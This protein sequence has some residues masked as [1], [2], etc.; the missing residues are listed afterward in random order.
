MTLEL[1]MTIEDAQ[2]FYRE[3]EK[4]SNTPRRWKEAQ[5]WLGRNDLFYLLSVLLRRPDVVHPWVFDRCRMVQMEPNGFL[6]LWSREHF[7]SSIITFGLTIQDVLNDP[8][9]TIAIFSHTKRIARG[10]LQQIMRELAGND[11]LKELYQDV[12][13]LNP[14]K[15]APMWSEEL[16]M[17][18]RRSHNPKEATIEAHGLVDGQPTSK[19]FKLRVYD[20]VV[21][22]ESV[23]TGDQIEKTTDAWSLSE[24]LGVQA[25]KGGRVRYIGTRYNLGDTYSEIIKRGAAI[26]RIFPATAN[27]RFDGEPVFFSQEE[28]DIR[29]RNQSRSTVAAQLLQNPMADESATFV[30]SWL[31]AYDVRPRTINVYIMVDPSMGRTATADCTA[32]AVVGVSATGGKYLLD[33]FCHRMQLSERWNRLKNLYRKWSRTPGVQHVAV[34]YERY[35]MQSDLEYINERMMLEHTHFPITELNWTR[36]NTNSKTERVAR[37]EPDFRNGRFYLSSAV[38]SRGVASYWVVGTN[39]E[40]KG[41]NEVEIRPTQG[42]SRVQMETIKS[43]SSDLVAKALKCADAE[44]K[45]YDLT[46]TFIEEYSSFP[47]GRL[48]DL[49]DAVSRIYDM[50]PQGPT[51]TSAELIEPT[52]FFDS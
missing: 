42:L 27:G 1:P 44:G 19:H 35:G 7:K 40:L 25:E 18:V 10:F 33:G 6:D 43:G 37:L 50:D 39:P 52:E 31:K 34:G 51:L 41:F 47:Y 8:N 11:V 12:L 5:R 26:P 49:I 3:M 24:N 21:T 28:W 16:G 32:M 30:N 29:V 2:A 23:A 14:E 15:Q 9:V 36:D 4:Q 13:F 17:I 46:L 38:L 20:D 48:K 45:L 22:R